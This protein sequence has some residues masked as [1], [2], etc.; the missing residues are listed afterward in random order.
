[1]QDVNVSNDLRQLSLCQVKALEYGRYDINGY[2]FQMVKLEA[3][4]PL[5]T[6]RNS[7][8]VANGEDASG[9]ATD[10][11]GILKKINEYT[12][13]GAKELK[14]VFFECD[15][16]D[17]VNSTRVDDFG[18][19]DVKHESRYLGNNL[20]FIHHVQQVY[21]LSY[22]HKGMKHWWVVYKV[23]TKMDTHRYDADVERHDDDNVVHVYQEE[24]EG[25][26]SLSFTVSNRVGFTELATH[27]VELMEEEPRPSK[28]RLQKSK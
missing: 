25:H 16:F 9:L 13:G 10:Y 6:T 5:A 21:Y 18:M 22:P 14:V 4:H 12:F 11:Y 26:Q 24:N 7:R 28:K 27:D 2:H 1:M 23:N 17:P 20:L 3:S 8:V 19:V 15:W